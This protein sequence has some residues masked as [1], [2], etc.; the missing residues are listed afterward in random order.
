MEEWRN[1][2]RLP[3]YQVSNLG[4]VKSLKRG[5]EKILKQSITNQ[6][7]SLVCLFSNGCRHTSYTHRLVAEEFIMRKSYL[8]LETAVV[9][10][11]DKNRTNNV[12]ENLEWCSPSE[13]IFHRDDPTSYFYFNKVSELCNQMNLDQLEKFIELGNKIVR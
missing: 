10:H 2:K 3:G 12:V 9:N 11:K 4:R 6:G 13:N 8:T 1:L 5:K 7:Y